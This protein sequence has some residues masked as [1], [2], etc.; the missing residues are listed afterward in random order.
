MLYFGGSA[1]QQRVSSAFL[2]NFNFPLPSID[3]QQEIAEYVYSIR[4]K[5]KQFQ[6]EGFTLLESTKKEVERMIIGKI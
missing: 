3:K 6:E 1:G 2:E 4:Q 5:A